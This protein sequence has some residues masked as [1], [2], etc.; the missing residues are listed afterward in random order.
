MESLSDTYKYFLYITTKYGNPAPALAFPLGLFIASP[1]Q[2]RTGRDS[3]GDRMK[4]SSIELQV[5][6]SSPH[7]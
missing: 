2:R 7:S 4:R 1:F 6:R 3:R 5:D